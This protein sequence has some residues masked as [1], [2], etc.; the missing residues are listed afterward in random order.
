MVVLPVGL[1]AAVVIGLVVLLVFH[2]AQYLADWLSHALPTINLGI[3]KIDL[4]A[5]V[6][7]GA[8][9]ALTKVQ[10]AFDSA[11]QPALNLILAP[12][13]IAK[14]LVGN[15]ISAVQEAAGTAAWIVLT[16][17]PRE[18][19]RTRTW[20]VGE[21][22]AAKAWAGAYTR[23]YLGY[24]EKYTRD[25]VGRA[26]RAAT[27]GLAG[28]RALLLSYVS[29]LLADIAAA[30]SKAEAWAGA[31]TRRYYAYAMSHIAALQA[32]LRRDVAIIGNTTAALG[33][34]ITRT[35]AGLSAAIVKAETSAIT[36]AVGAIDTG[37]ADAA[38]VTWGAL[39]TAV[40]DVTGVLA[41]DFPDITAWVKDIPKAAVGDIAGVTTL[42]I[43]TAGILARYLEKCGAPNCRNL[44]KIGRD[45]QD[46]FA[47]AE[48]GALL[49]LLGELIAD[50]VGGA[51]LV[52]DDLYGPVAGLA[53]DAA[54]L[55]GVG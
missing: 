37:I 53:Q 15:I 1:L 54:N 10:D 38:H 21:V 41:T 29:H 51:R 47:F 22:T 48:G 52:H 6:R 12:V 16:F 8:I 39:D 31:Y 7:A 40:A 33:A 4:G 49:G 11:L 3:K 46:L 26:I 36:G 13:Y 19:G 24:A 14:N 42:S 18:I 43:A 20:V 44:S 34:T 45:L 50:P 2:G 32:E 35:A 25:Y 55:L 5:V 30:V 28:L 17:V 27:G 9:L 23:R